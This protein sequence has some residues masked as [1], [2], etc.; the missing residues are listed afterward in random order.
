MI[1][2]GTVE[3]SLL[4]N[5]ALQTIC[6]FILQ[7]GSLITIS[8]NSSLQLVLKIELISISNTIIKVVEKFKLRLQDDCNFESNSTQTIE[9]KQNTLI[10]LISDP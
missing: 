9:P 1:I 2:P 3:R 7:S 10:E 8:N 6:N 4:L 5:L